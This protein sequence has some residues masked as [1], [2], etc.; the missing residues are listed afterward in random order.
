LH[1]KGKTLSPWL[2]T[3][4]NQ[5]L[6]RSVLSLFLRFSLSRTLIYIWPLDF[7]VSLPLRFF[8]LLLFLLP[9]AVACTC[10]QRE[11]DIE[12]AQLREKRG[13]QRWGTS[14]AASGRLT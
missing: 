5:R 9:P 11:R 12:S 13:E 6:R 8:L 4:R 14:A 10:T 3:C 2:A 7:F 1:F